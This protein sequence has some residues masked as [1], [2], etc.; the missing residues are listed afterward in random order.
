MTVSMIWAQDRNRV[1]GTGSGM[2]WHVPDDFKFFKRSTMGAPVIMGRA[3][4]E[5]LGAKPLPGRRNFVLTSQADYCAAGAIV[6]TSLE[7]ALAQAKWA[8]DQVWIAGGGKV[9]QQGM[10]LADELVVTSLDLELPAGGQWVY[11]PKIDEDV[12]AVDSQRSDS[13]WR[14]KSGDAR[15]KVT[16]FLRRK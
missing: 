16:Y 11:A 5:A 13:T 2:A 12:W 9:Y 7:D 6:C 14:A 15:W 10:A 1:L 8:S 3:S 4:W